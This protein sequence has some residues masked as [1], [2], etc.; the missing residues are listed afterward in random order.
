MRKRLHSVSDYPDH[1][2]TLKETDTDQPPKK[3]SGCKG[4]QDILGCKISQLLD[5]LCCIVYKRGNYSCACFDPSND[6]EGSGKKRYKESTRREFAQV[7][8]KG[9]TCESTNGV[10]S[11]L[12]RVRNEW[13][14]GG[15]AI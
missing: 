7:R 1:N 2:L 14:G 11:W 6:C 10:L 15:G 13:D 5:G 8:D 9:R 12:V 4:A 3:T